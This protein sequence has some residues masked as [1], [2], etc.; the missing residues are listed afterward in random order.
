MADPFVQEIAI[1]EFEVAPVRPP[2]SD[3]ELSKSESERIIAEFISANSQMFDFRTKCQKLNETYCPTSKQPSGKTQIDVPS[4]KGL[5]G[6]SQKAGRMLSELMAFDDLMGISPY[7]ITDVNTDN[8]H[9]LERKAERNQATANYLLELGHFKGTALLK[10]VWNATIHPMA[11]AETGFATDFR[12]KDGKEIPIAQYPHCRALS[13]FRVAFDLASDSVPTGRFFYKIYY[14]SDI[15]VKRHAS[16]GYYDPDVAREI[17]FNSQY[18]VNG[19][20]DQF[21]QQAKE[22]PE[23]SYDTGYATIVDGYTYLDPEG[24][25]PTLYNVVFDYASHKFL[26]VK[27][28]INNHGKIPVVGGMMM[29]RPDT[30]TGVSPLEQIFYTLQE[31]NYFRN[32]AATNTALAAAITLLTQKDAGINLDVLKKRVFGNIIVGDNV[33]PGAIR[34]LEM[35]SQLGDIMQFLQMIDWDM[36]AAIGYNDLT[37]ALK[38]PDT[39]KGAQI[40]QAQAQV[41]QEI[42]TIIFVQTFLQPLFEMFWSDIQQFFDMR[43]WIKLNGEP[44][45]VSQQDLQGEYQVTVGDLVAQAKAKINGQAIM[46]SMAMLGQTGLTADY[47]KG[48]RYGWKGMGVPS[49]VADDILPPGMQTPAN[50]MKAQGFMGQNEL[51]N[52]D[53]RQIEG[54]PTQVENPGADVPPGPIG[55]RPPQMQRGLPSQ[56]PPEAVIEQLLR[57]SGGGYLGE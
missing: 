35:R 10:S 5:V 15:D 25:G 31:Y 21:K 9:D 16:S 38:S 47:G 20:L 1:T 22:T 30:L 32:M 51:Q 36:S 14:L 37:L 2:W 8:F 33:S 45:A 19:F 50:M 56:V 53:P 46:Q 39:A 18:D 29:I 17:D 40:M 42:S 11:F 4:L 41:N 6:V 26:R 54:N 43:V 55:P 49:H 27:Q 28:V 12:V 57:K 48:F 24:N 44:V 7:L 3:Y 52:G 23:A 34:Q 13:P